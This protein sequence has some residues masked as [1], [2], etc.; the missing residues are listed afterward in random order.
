MSFTITIN[1]NDVSVSVNIE[2]LQVVTNSI[3]RP[4]DLGRLKERA[5]QEQGRRPEDIRHNREGL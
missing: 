5:A 1:H 4:R 3:M 2:N